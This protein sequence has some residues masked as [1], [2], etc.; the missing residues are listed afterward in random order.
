MVKITNRTGATKI[1]P[2]TMLWRDVPLDVI[3]PTQP[4]FG[5]HGAVKTGRPTLAP[6]QITLRGAIYYR[7]KARIRRELDN[8]LPFLMLGPLQVYQHQDDNR[9]MIAEFLGAPQ[10]WLDERVDLRLRI[11]LLATDPHWYGREVAL[12][13]SGTQTITVGGN[14]PTAPVIKATG[15]GSGLAVANHTNGDAIIVSS[16]GP[17]EVDSVNQT[18]LVNQAERIDLINREWVLGRRGT[19]HG[20]ELFPG[21]NRLQTSRAIEIKYYPRWW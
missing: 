3:I 15:T 4:L 16:G 9:F 21:E 19:E 13:L 12:N 5:R 10:E 20:F 2:M 18:C 11:H 1:L 14:A 7:D 6:R 17:V 8:L